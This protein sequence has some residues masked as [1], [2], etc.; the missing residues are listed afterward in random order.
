MF[1]T[2]LA[3]TI[4]APQD[5]FAPPVR[6]TAGGEP[7]KVEAPGYAAP[8]WADVTGDGKKDLLVG[9]FNGGKI[10]VFKNLGQG[11]LEAGKWLEAEGDV[12]EVPGVW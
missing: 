5:Q 2:L 4:A 9:Q 11:K 7:V 6:L 8:C 3:A 10:R 1:L 12:A